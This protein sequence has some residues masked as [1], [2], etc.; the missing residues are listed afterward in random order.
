MCVLER[1]YPE[2][3]MMAFET[4]EKIAA[5]IGDVPVVSL[6][7]NCEPSL[8]KRLPDM[9]ALL[10]R[11][12]PRVFATFTTNGTALNLRLGDA[13]IESGLDCMQVSVD[14]ARKETFEKIRVGAEFEKVM[15]N[16]REFSERKRVKASRTPEL[17]FVFTA[18]TENIDEL[19]GVID[20]AISH[21]AAAVNV[22]GLESY[23]P[24]LDAIKLWS[25]KKEPAESVRRMREA[26][27]HARRKGIRLVLSRLKT[28]PVRYC[29]L[30]NPVIAWNGT[31]APCSPLSYSRPI[32]ADGE[33]T[34]LP[35]VL[36]GN[37]AEKPFYEVWNSKNYASFRRSTLRG[38]LPDYC[39]GCLLKSRVTCAFDG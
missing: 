2:K 7:N 29:A 3:G 35:Q 4:F 1:L 24:E 13:I 5:G 21:G 9:V 38:K 8:N 16:V 34:V 23:S 36:F 19:P 26:T 6:S 22:N 31:I 11:N 30:T 12:N 27:E 25:T 18:S 17:Q 15:A 14:G 39:K 33:K 10:K 37:V 28:R 32:Y 20:L